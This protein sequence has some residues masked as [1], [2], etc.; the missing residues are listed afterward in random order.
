[1][2]YV[3]G[4]SLRDKLDREGQLPVQ[5][6]LR[7]TA[8]VAGA[9]DHAH[10][11]GV[12][13]RD[14]KPANILLTEGG[15]VVA[16]FGIAHALDEAGGERLT[17]TGVAIGTPAYM[18]P[19]QMGEA[20]L[21]GRADQYSLACVLYEMLAGHPPFAGATAQVIMAR[22]AADEVPPL[23]SVRKTVPVGIEAAI[24]RA[25]E[26]APADR[27]P[28]CTG[29]A[30]ALAAGGP[31]RKAWPKR[32]AVLVAL[33]AVAATALAYVGGQA[34]IGTAEPSGAQPGPPAVELIA[35]RVAVL[36]FDNRTGDSS[37]AMIALGESMAR[38]IVER[39]D[40]LG[41]VE[42]VPIR[43]LSDLAAEEP[44]ARLGA[45][46][47]ARHTE[48]RI[49]VTGAIYER[50]DSLEVTAEVT[51]VADGRTVETAAPTRVD[52]SDPLPDLE[53]V[54]SDVA[55]AVA[56]YADPWS[57]RFGLRER[58]SMPNLEAYREFSEGVRHDTRSETAAASTRYRAAWEEDTT[59]LSALYLAAYE[60]MPSMEYTP[61]ADSLVRLLEARRSRLSS[62]QLDQLDGLRAALAG[63]L[64]ARLELARRKRDADPSDASHG[65]VGYVAL[66]AYRPQEALE[67][68]AAIDTSRA[69]FARES[70]QFWRK[71]A[72][73]YHALGRHEEE[74][75]VAR[76][77]VQRFAGRSEVNGAD[78]HALAALGRVDEIEDVIDRFRGMRH[79]AP[80][81]DM[82]NE[83]FVA[84]RICR[85]HG[86]PDCAER[87]VA[88][89]LA[90]YQE[91]YPDPDQTIRLARSHLAAG[92]TAVADSLY[93]DLS[94]I[95]RAHQEAGRLEEAALLLQVLLQ[96]QPD[97]IAHHWYYGM[98][99]AQLGDEETA[100]EQDRWLAEDNGTLNR[101]DWWRS[102]IYAHL[103]RHDR[104]IE[105]LRRALAEG[106][107]VWPYYQKHWL[108]SEPLWGN[109]D[110]EEL[111]EPKG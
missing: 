103:G 77:G 109:P 80:W 101:R 102:G 42:T 9:L 33:A 3:E 110:F 18:A 104:A 69:W 26:K 36:P 25:M 16:D 29:F 105:L 44:T 68:F 92:E 66:D 43:Q 49:L 50:G 7:I 100:L 99:A 20:P 96:D 53:A 48:A 107:P 60:A 90:Y 86:H 37:S 46:G 70:A 85:A 40:G 94:R 111:L 47:L 34:V 58:P 67:A 2:P 59:F 10:A 76:E 13:H 14:I 4:E 84:V 74:L 78:M 21:D 83:W 82:A 17:R 31:I 93:R 57:E 22:H 41:T 1:M 106:M 51:D 30:E 54:W 91:R 81:S 38:A 63:D 73:I 27:F 71:W 98:L 64:Q 35:H 24:Q 56:F 95:A 19:E 23:A 88:G 72:E 32:R 97:R 15:A 55:G 79:A 39:L 65:S 28:S 52:P 62:L 75:E 5:D 11:Q 61:R 45:M 87:L 6:A 12:V 8:E 89:L 108:S